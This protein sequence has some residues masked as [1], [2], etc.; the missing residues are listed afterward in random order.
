MGEPL[1]VHLDDDVHVAVLDEHSETG[2][3]KSQIVNQWAKAGERDS[4][5]SLEDSF[6]PAFGQGLFVAG[7]ILPF[8]V[9]LWLGW[10]VALVGLSVVMGS[11]VDY[12][13]SNGALSYGDAFR[14]A[15]GI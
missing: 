1:T 10:G 11:K 3:S 4:A 6:L 15:M 7:F 8:F 13:L 5:T 9:S 12:P 2:Q 14:R